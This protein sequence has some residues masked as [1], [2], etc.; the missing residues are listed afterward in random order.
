VRFDD[1]WSYVTGYVRIRV[2]GPAPER[3]VNLA[4][5]RGHRLWRAGRTAHGLEVNT[6][7][8]SFRRLGRIRRR[9]GSRIRIV[10]RRGLPFAMAKAGRRPLL[11]GGAVASVAAVYLLSSMIWFVQIEGA[12]RFDPGLLREVCTS[13]GL[14]PGVF[15]WSINPR[16]V[17]RGM[18]VAVNGLSWVAVEIHGVVAVVKVVEKNPLERP[19]IIL[20]PADVVAAKDGVITSIIVLAGRAVVNEGATV[21]E[22][23]LLIQGRQFVPT[24]EPPP[25]KPGEKPP[26]RPEVDVVAKGIVRARVWY[27]AYAE[28]ALHTLSHE[29]TGR[30][31]QRVD[32]RVL[33]TTI[34]VVG[35]WNPPT[36]LFERHET[37]TRLPWWR[38]TGRSVEIVTTV[39]TEMRDLRRDLS[40]QE[41]EQVARDAAGA[42]LTR[43]IPQGAGPASYHFEVTRRNDILIGV[44]ATAEIIEDIAR[45]KPKR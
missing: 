45:T 28:A 20:P 17:E 10:E 21:K 19:D 43:L 29:P 27:Q 1:L 24:P 11:V 31:W 33:G 2:T 37:V 44:A 34:P 13:Q 22:G 36:G 7:I 18:L 30:T 35:W 40:P 14:Q 9:T 8:A 42:S 6:T 41:A 12:E 5:A 3:F 25:L 4:A 15:K 26:P 39:F 23:D 38:A 16:Q 32:L